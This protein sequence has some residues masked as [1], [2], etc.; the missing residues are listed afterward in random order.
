MEPMTSNLPPVLEQRFGPVEYRSIDDIVPYAR[1]LRKHPER[2]LVQL[3]A[4]MREFGFVMPLLIDDSCT[5]I[6]GHARLEAAKRLGMKTVPVLVASFWSAAQIKAYRLADNQLASAATWD[7]DLLRIE[8]AEIIDVAEVSVEVLGWS[9][10]EIDVI[11]DDA[12]IEAEEPGD[13]VPAPPAVPASRNGDLWLLGKHR[14]LCGSSLEPTAWERLMAG[15]TAAMSL[16]DPPYNVPVNGHVSGSGRHAEFAMASGEMTAAEFT[17]FNATYLTNMTAHL[18]DGA[19]IMA[20][21][22]HAHIADLMTAGRQAGLRHMN[23]CVWVKSNGGMGSLWR[24]QHELVLVLKHGTAPHTNAVELG[25]HGRYRTNVWMAPGANSF[26]KT[27]DKDLADHPTVKPIGLLA[28]AIRDVTRH[29][30]IVI[31]AFSG[32]GS[33]ILACERTGRV[34]YAV[35]IAARYIDV[36]IQRFEAMTGNSVVLE[37][38]GETYAQVQTR[39]AAEAQALAA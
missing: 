34:G 36:A 12:A 6:C 23:L 13:D 32:S 15:K 9:T 5:L 20:F 18:K 11:L 37:E 29:G 28:D 22:D 7:D 35:E 8:L 21:M 38:T 10:G 24:S 30:E 19:I 27:R 39:R 26:S 2:Q 1:A 14:L 16:T 3:T 25:K 17:Q 4:S 31:D 33:T